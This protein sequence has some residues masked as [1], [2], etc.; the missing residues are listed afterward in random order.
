MDR[1][2]KQVPELASLLDRLLGSRS[3]G[4]LRTGARAS[5]LCTSLSSAAW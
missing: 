2:L 3:F 1:Y 5:P 4:R